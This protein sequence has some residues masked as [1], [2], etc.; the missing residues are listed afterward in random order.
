MS[1]VIPGDVV[2]HIMWASFVMQ[3]FG[4]LGSGIYW[5]WECIVTGTGPYPPKTNKLYFPLT[6]NV[7]IPQ[8]T[9]FIG[10]LSGVLL[11]TSLQLLVIELSSHKLL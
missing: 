7:I 9:F 11:T 2:T 6:S 3:R 4:L 5:E 10:T 8:S 1:H